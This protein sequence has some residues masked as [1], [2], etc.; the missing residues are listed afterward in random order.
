M[1]DM[2]PEQELAAKAAEGLVKKGLL[3]S[4]SREEF[5][6]KFAA[7]TLRPYDWKRMFERA[8]DEA[9]AAKGEVS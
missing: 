6:K 1:A 3:K 2:G 9:D 8:A 5:E 7:G 4:M